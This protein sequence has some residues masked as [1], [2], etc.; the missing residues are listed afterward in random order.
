MQNL[1]LFGQM[2]SDKEV[3]ENVDKH[4]MPVPLFYY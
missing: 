2:V 1:S 4:R 3:F